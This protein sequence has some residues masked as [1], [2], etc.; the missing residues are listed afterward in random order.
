MLKHGAELLSDAELIGILLRTGR[1]GET[2][3]AVAR[4]VLQQV[5]GLAGLSATELAALRSMPGVGEVKA[6]ILVA[7]FELAR[8]W[9]RARAPITPSIEES[10]DLFAQYHAQLRARP[11]EGMLVVALDARNRLLSDTWIPGTHHQTTIHQREVFTFLLQGRAAAFALLHNH[12]SG[13]TTPSQADRDTTTH[14][15][16]L[17]QLMELPLMDH[18]II[19][20]DAYFSFRDE[21]MLQL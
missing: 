8:R 20:H 1:R 5:D 13:D 11:R 10:H 2:A 18:L 6:I 19:G 12:P 4:R 21:G 16:A 14:L 7:V 3:V 9:H 17:G 15:L